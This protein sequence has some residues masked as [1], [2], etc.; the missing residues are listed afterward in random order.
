[1][2][3]HWLV[4][5]DRGWV[6][7]AGHSLATDQHCRNIEFGITSYLVRGSTEDASGSDLEFAL[8]DDTTDS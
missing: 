7:F 6:A 4:L 2:N 3:K 8:I 5:T 1:M